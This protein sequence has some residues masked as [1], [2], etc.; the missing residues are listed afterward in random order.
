MD[1]VRARRHACT[2]TYKHMR[3]GGTHGTTDLSAPLGVVLEE[4]VEGHELLGEALAD[5]QPVHRHD[6]LLFCGGFVCLVGGFGCGL[7]G[8][9]FRVCVNAGNKP[10]RADKYLARFNT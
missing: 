2:D 7:N 10:T 6:H 4:G 5:V 9:V 8:R 3:I 1:A